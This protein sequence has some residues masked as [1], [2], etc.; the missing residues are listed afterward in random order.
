VHKFRNAVASRFAAA[1]RVARS[2]HLS[3]RS[4]FDDRAGHNP[5]HR[6]SG[7]FLRLLSILVI[8]ATAGSAKAQTTYSTYSYNSGPITLTPGSAASCAGTATITGYMTVPNGYPPGYNGQGEVAVPATDYSFT[9]GGFTFTT[10]N[11][12]EGGLVGIEL[13]N[14]QLFDAGANIYT[15]DGQHSMVFAVTPSYPRANGYGSNIVEN[16]QPGA[17][18]GYQNFFPGTLSGNFITKNLGNP[19]QPTSN[20]DVPSSPFNP[21]LPTYAG[22][23]GCGAWCGNPIDAATGNK[24]QIETDFA[25]G[26]GTQLSLTRYYNSQDITSS[27]FGAG[28]HSTWHRSLNPISASTVIVTRADGREDTFTLNAGVWQADPDVTSVLTPIP[29][30]GTQTGWQLVTADDTTEIY[31]LAGQLASVTTRAGLTTTLAYNAAGQLTS[32]TGP[33]GATL[34]FLN[35]ANGLVN[36]MIAPDGG[37][38]YYVYDANNNL[39]AAVHPDGSFRQYV[40]GNASFPNALTGIIDENGSQYASWSYDAQGRAVSSQHAGGADLTTVAYNADGS[41][42]VTDAN[43]NTHSYTLLTQFSLVKPTSLSGAPY[44][45]SGGQAFTYDSNGFLAS[46]TDYDGNVTAYTH[47]ARGDETSRTEASGSAIARTI[48]TT[49]LP[50]FHLPGS[51]AEPNRVTSFAYDASGNLLQKT[52]T[53]GAKTRSW[54]YTYNGAGQAL[55]ATDPDG[56]TTAFTYDAAGNLATVTDALGNVTALTGYDADGRLLS[57]TDPNGLV[58]SFT[59]NFRGQVTARNAGGEVTS[60]AYDPAGQLIKTTLPDGSFFALAYDPAHRLTG[61][62]DAAGDSVAYTLDPASNVT[63]TQIF[64]PGGALTQTRSYAYDQVNRVAQAIGAQGQTTA[65]AYDPNSNLTGVS[66]PLSHVTGY[67]Y[68]ALNRLIQGLDPNGGKTAYAY[69]VLD[70]VT[71]VTD[72]RKL[73]TTYGWNA[74]DDQTSVTSPDSGVTTRTFDAAGNVASSTDARGLKTTY[75]YDALNRPI[76]AAY[77]DGTVVTWHYDQGTY[78]IGH[79]TKM[80]DLSGSTVWTYDQHGRV[81]TKKQT[82]GGLTLVTKMAYDAAGRLDKLTYP[83]GAVIKVS[84]DAAG[85]ISG[86]KSGGASLVGGVGYLPF[87]P[88]ESWNQGNG[89]AYTRG[90]DQDGRI[91]SI[92]FGGGTIALA[93]DAASRI[94]GI[95]E[96]GLPAK[97]FGYD[98]LDRLTAYTSGATALTYGYDANG[99]RTSLGG[100]SSLSYG[101]DPASNRLL[102]AGSR[103]FTYD[104]AGN[105]TADNQPLLIL[106]YAYDASGRMVTAKTGGYTTAYTNDGLG[107]RVT[108]SGYGASTFAGGAEEFVYD[109][110]GHLLGEYDG[111]GAAIQETIW[112][113]DLPVAVLLPGSLT[114]YVAP[115]QLGSP[116]QLANAGRGTAWLWDHDPFGNGAPTGA[117]TY[118]P[119]F[120]GQYYDGETGLHYN[121][122]RDYDPST[123]R[124]VQSDPIGL[125]GGINTYAYVRANP[126]HRIDALGLTNITPE[127]VIDYLSSIAEEGK[128]LMLGA[129]SKGI[130]AISGFLQSLKSSLDVVTSNLQPT[131]NALNPFA[132]AQSIPEWYATHQSP[133]PDISQGYR[134]GMSQFPESK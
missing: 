93:Y 30:T 62:T 7:R 52:V 10:S 41:S 66:D 16:L 75:R 82:S 131:A 57:M 1:C 55:T 81:L 17:N 14:G 128:G 112:L 56:N 120:P 80:I 127:T 103:S 61:I 20:R 72:P 76:K 51:I 83:S 25:G 40:Y 90:F 73:K 111:T 119:R 118:N 86:L 22:P 132:T 19:S 53:A 43:G 123:G 84:Y 94:T 133:P 29:A 121:G 3:G 95:N 77:A 102:T 64:A 6:S 60:Y 122:F 116:H 8:A 12:I 69:D 50:N 2:F 35:G 79:L 85:R 49:W 87:G 47:D 63:K 33:F 28:W 54:A 74:L 39:T 9:A 105:V 129:C 106:G 108:R 34:T 124:Y 89:A 97:S 4:A 71:K 5:R 37:G 23:Y 13:N 27:A 115:D 18:C 44:P 15:A 59:Y 99:N 78:G 92:G 98:A 100:S 31:T 65:F 32:V 114:D 117:A 107:E 67:A 109:Q 42:S 68:D 11:S 130:G 24:F 36:E 126:I 91:A 101:I 96:T 26:P 113:G 21:A 70:H 38:Y 104:A 48:A 125:V 46:R 110:A 58:T 45:A 134:N 88:A